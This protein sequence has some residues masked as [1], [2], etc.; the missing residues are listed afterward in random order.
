M[1]TV[2]NADEQHEIAARRHRCALCGDAKQ[3][4]HKKI[5]GGV[6]AFICTQCAEDYVQR[7]QRVQAQHEPPK[8]LLIEVSAPQLATVTFN[9]IVEDLKRLVDDYLE[10]EGFGADADIRLIRGHE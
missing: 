7:A 4:T 9:G 6:P 8:K 1:I 2:L 3:L 5:S 10:E